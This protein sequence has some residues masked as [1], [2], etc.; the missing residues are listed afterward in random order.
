MRNTDELHLTV[1]LLL[2]GGDET[3]T[4]GRYADKDGLLVKVKYSF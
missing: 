1:G 3:G 2:F 4:F